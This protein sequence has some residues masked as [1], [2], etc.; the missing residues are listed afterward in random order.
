MYK[1]MLIDDDVPMLRYIQH[2]INWNELGIVISDSMYSSE[3]ALE[4]FKSRRPDIIITDIG[5]PHMNG[6]ALA[7]QFRRMHPEVRIIFLT[8]H[9]DFAYSKQAFQ[10]SADDYL[11]KDELTKD[12]L[13]IS[14]LK[15]IE[16]L[17][18]KQ[19]DLERLSYREDL[20]RNK[21]ILK[22]KFLEQIL[23]GV[24]VRTTIVYG[25]RLGIDWIYPHCILG[26]GEIRLD[27]F[28]QHYDLKDLK[29]V[30]YAIYN[31][32]EEL[33]SEL[34]ERITPFLFQERLLLI[35]NGERTHIERLHSTYKSFLQSVNEKAELYLK[36][37]MTYYTHQAPITISNLG[38]HYADM[39]KRMQEFF[40]ETGWLHNMDKTP[41]NNWLQTE[42]EPILRDFEQ[43]KLAVIDRNKLA[44]DI[45]M[46][47]IQRKSNQ[48]QLHPQKMIHECLQLMR[49]V[50][51]VIGYRED[52]PLMAYLNSRH[53]CMDMLE[54]I[55]HVC[56]AM[57][58]HD[59]IQQL[60]TVKDP[61]LEMI[62]RFIEHHIHETVT[63]VDTANHLHL[64]P[65]YFSRYFKKMTQMNFTDYVHQFKIKIAIQLLQKPDETVENVA[66][67][68]GYSDRAYFSKVFKKYSG[69]SPSDYKSMDHE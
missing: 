61:K 38:I 15:A 32:A 22:E 8:C 41:D 30:L 19:I 62:D 39:G 7:Q 68:L 11:I 37:R 20:E 64:N 42:Y 55:Q 57:F 10:L 63:S 36:V 4:A 27:L 67:S 28:A 45:A 2:L 24:N 46:H 25:K 48:L 31:I 47:S 23:S 17:E 12:Q 6:I 13:E 16:H 59:A 49:A 43:W 65:S 40:Y 53:K 1:L 35:W 3:D 44:A 29:L 56:F 52:E 58:S 33:S 60:G 5:M 18:H 69:K 9:E 50:A 14:L 51:L 66:Y 54:F 34:N 26:L 21:D